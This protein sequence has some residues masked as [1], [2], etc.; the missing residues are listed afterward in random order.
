MKHM[1]MWALLGLC[2]MAAVFMLGAVNKAFIHEAPDRLQ[3]SI[4]AETTIDEVITQLPGSKMLDAN[5]RVLSIPYGKVDEY[6]KLAAALPGVIQPRAMPLA[7][8]E[9]S[10]RY[11]LF[12]V[13]KLLIDY[14]HGDLGLIR[15]GDYQIQVKSILMKSALRTFTYFIPGLIVGVLIA[16]MLGL[17]ASISRLFGKWLDSAHAICSGVPDYLLIIFIQ[18]V[19]IYITRMTGRNV[20][21]VAQYG[22]HIPFMIP[23][24]TIA[25]I[26]GV[27]IYGTLRLAIE[28]EMTQD[29]LTTA[30]AKG[31]SHRGVIVRH[32]IRNIMEDLIMVL[33][34]ATTLALASMAV[35][36]AMCDILGL[37]G[38][39]VSPRMQNIS[40]TPIICI[41]L[42]FL[43]IVIN[44]LY[45]LLGKLFVVQIREGR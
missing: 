44:I 3:V 20:I 45:A 9:I 25:F 39:I 33:P 10:F 5:V 2:T 26:P 35:A 6:R 41:V 28:R 22:N 1:M 34:K 36:E 29:Y 8:T 43:A 14:S 12:S 16:V 27:L 18:L 11:Y 40:A 13:K 42:A 37:G 38:Y 32:V 15:T 24:L 4:S 19:S 31:L 7:K 17:L 23:F 30:R 21:L